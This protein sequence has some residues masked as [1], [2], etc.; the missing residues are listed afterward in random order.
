[1]KTEIKGALA[2]FVEVEL[3]PGESVLAEVGSLLY[4]EAS[5]TEEAE[6]PGGFTAGVL[7]KLAGTS[8]FLVRC[9][10]PGLCSFSKDHAGQVVELE[11]DQQEILLQHRA[12]LL[13]E[14]GVELGLGVDSGAT[15][16]GKGAFSHL[17]ALRLQGR[18]KVTAVAWGDSQKIVLGRGERIYAAPGRVMALERSVRVERARIGG[19]RE[20]LTEDA[21]RVVLEGPGAVWLQSRDYGSAHPEPKVTATNV[22]VRRGQ[23]RTTKRPDKDD[24][25]EESWLW[26][27]HRD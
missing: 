15:L 21:R 16:L 18:G 20:L 24:R 5:V 22:H 9:R 7:R 13:A 8:F 25:R 3:E 1:M 2:P 26:D 12:F 6:I 10:G 27:G 23:R 11:V 14:P 19:W 4:R 17:L